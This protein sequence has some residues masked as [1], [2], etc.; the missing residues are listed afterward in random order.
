M[1]DKAKRL[2]AGHVCLALFSGC[3]IIA[4]QLREIQMFHTTGTLGQGLTEQERALVSKMADKIYADG[5][6]LRKLGR[7][8]QGQEII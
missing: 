6:L 1:I 3:N 7:R 5:E 2:A 8:F 4:F